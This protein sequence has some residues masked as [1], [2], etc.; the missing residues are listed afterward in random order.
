ML[1]YKTFKRKGTKR[2]LYKMKAHGESC[3]IPNID[4]T[5]KKAEKSYSTLNVDKATRQK[6]KC[7]RQRENKERR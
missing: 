6:A 3:K 1:I 5:P 4:F 7:I 2:V